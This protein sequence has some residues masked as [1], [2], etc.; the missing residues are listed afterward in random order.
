[1]LCSAPSP[2]ARDSTLSKTCR[3]EGPRMMTSRRRGRPL[4]LPGDLPAPLLRRRREGS[5]SAF[6][7]PLDRPPSGLVWEIV[8]RGVFSIG[9]RAMATCLT[10]V[11]SQQPRIARV[12]R[13]VLVRFSLQ[14]HRREN[15]S[16]PPPEAGQEGERTGG[17]NAV[18]IVASSFL[19]RSPS[20]AVW[21]MLFQL[22][23]LTH[24]RNPPARPTN[25]H[26]SS[27]VLA[28]SSLFPGRPPSAAER[29]ILQALTRLGRLLRSMCS[30]PL[31]RP[32]S[33]VVWCALIWRMMQHITQQ[34]PSCSTQQDL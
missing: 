17:S 26:S 19:G 16:F 32:P 18:G 9:V 3:R 14:E 25:Y 10:N 23:K 22:P 2:G 8:R 34:Q 21:R 13:Q 27:T 1:M 24:L 29:Q 7:L 6:S 20:G 5:S 30:T 15:Y 12:T 33:G 31:G 4:P 28:V 11:I